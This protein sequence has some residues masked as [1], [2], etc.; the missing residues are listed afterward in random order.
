MGFQDKYLYDRL[1]HLSDSDIYPYHMPG[2]KRNMQGYPMEELYRIDITEIDDFDNLHQPQDILL[3]LQN[4]ISAIYHTEE[5][6]CLINGSSC[7]VLSA[8]TACAGRHSKILLARNSHKSAYHA[9]FQEELTAIY[10]EPEII[11]DCDLCGAIL[12]QQVE[13]ALR[14]HSDCNTVMITS[15]TY[16][17]IVTDVRAIADIV[18]AHGGVLIVDEA[19]GAH[20]CYTGQEA[21]SAVS[22]GA[23]LVVQSIHKTLPAPTQTALLHVCSK[24]IDLNRIRRALRIYQSS[25]PSY[26]LLAGI[27]QCF[28]ILE[29]EGT[30]RCEEFIQRCNKL[31]KEI[32]RLKHIHLIP[33]K[34]ADHRRYGMKAQDMG[35]MVISVKNTPMTGQQL[36]DMLLETYH[37]QMELAQGSYVV[38]I[39]TLMDSQEGFERLGRALLEIDR[40][41]ADHVSLQPPEKTLQVSSRGSLQAEMTI[42]EAMEEKAE[43][44]D[45]HTCHGRIAAEFVNVYPP[46]IPLIVPGERYTK[47]ITDVILQNLKYGLN[48]Q[49]IEK[50][51][52]VYV[53]QT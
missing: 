12:P 15:P 36:Y 9:I 16:E 42:Y 13:T 47:E 19:H 17:G 24:R 3:R 49:G 30:S 32:S 52:K 18:H 23:D 39:M 34:T 7:G 33:C 41:I 35:K 40:G 2:H 22:M 48:V 37:L 50:N 10:M 11:E 1:Q 8:I 29:A 38:A 43:L 53:V 6:F 51:Q 26:V 28:R 4:R 46:G 45:I 20:L 44:C 25:S 27:D 5:S 14:V 31:R 21:L